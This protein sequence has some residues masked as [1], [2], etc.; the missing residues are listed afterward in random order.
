[1]LIKKL[2]ERGMPSEKKT[3][4]SSAAD[5]EWPDEEEFEEVE[6]IRGEESKEAIPGLKEVEEEI[7]KTLKTKV[8]KAGRRRGLP[9]IRTT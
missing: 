5:I 4:V 2:K 1:M 3:K 7:G 6:I 9:S 8:P